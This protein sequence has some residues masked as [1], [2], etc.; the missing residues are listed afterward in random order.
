MKGP[1]HL[2]QI[3]WS[4]HTTLSIILILIPLSRRLKL[5][6]KDSAVSVY[7]LKLFK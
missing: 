2:D 4:F 1:L 5:N 7:Y 6:R 3:D